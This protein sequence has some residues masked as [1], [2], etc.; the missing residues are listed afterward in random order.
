MFDDVWGERAVLIDALAQCLAVTQQVRS[1]RERAQDRQL[2]AR[3]AQHATH[4]DIAM[5]FAQRRA[6]DRDLTVEPVNQRGA[7]A[8]VDQQLLFWR[9]N[10]GVGAATFPCHA[11][12]SMT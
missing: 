1:D 10:S 11:F 8:P 6:Y 5:G 12:A 4:R 9:P 7:V 2:S 3:E